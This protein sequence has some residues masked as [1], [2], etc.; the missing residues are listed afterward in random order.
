MVSTR[1]QASKR[2][3]EVASS[4][5]SSSEAA[6]DDDSIVEEEAEEPPKPVCSDEEDIHDD[7]D[8]DKD[9]KDPIQRQGSS[10]LFAPYRSVGIVNSGGGFHLVPNQNSAQA[11]AACPIGDRFQLLQCDRLHPVLVSQAVATAA[12]TTSPAHK[13]NKEAAERCIQQV[14][15]DASL[16]IAVA[17]HGPTGTSSVDTVTLFQRTQPIASRMLCNRTK[18]NVMEVLSLGRIHS[19]VT[20]D[21]EKQGKKEN[22]A[23]IAVILAKI[24]QDSDDSSVPVVGDDDDNSSSSSDDESISSEDDDQHQETCLGRIVIL[25]ASRTGLV[26]H[27]RIALADAPTFVPRTGVHPATFLNKI[28]LG[29]C[30]IKN[31]KK[32]AACI[33]VNVRTGKIVHN[34]RCVA[35]SS[36]AVVTAL[37]QAPA[38]DTVAI[39]TDRG[40]VHLVNLKYDKVLFTLKHKAKRG[41]PVTVTSMSFRTDGSAMQ[42][43]IAPMAVGRSDGNVTVWDLTKPEDEQVGRTILCEMDNVHPG[44]VA[45]LEYFPQEPLLLSTGTTSNSIRMHIFD[46]PDHSSRLLRQRNGHTAPPTRIRYLHPGAGAGNGLMVNASDGTDASSCQILSSGGRDR[47]LRIFSTA[48]SV[49]DKEFSQGQGLEKKA[50]KLGLEDRSELLL[51]SLTALATSEVRSRDWGDL[52]TI[53]QDHSLAYVWNTQRGAQSGPVLRQKSWNVSNMQ[54][55]PPSET[56]ATAV[57]IS[58][59][60]NFALIGTKGGTIYRYNV[61]SGLARGSFPRDA[62]ILNEG[63]NKLGAIG[64]VNRTKKALEKKLKTASRSANL[65]KKWL[66]AQETAKKQQELDAKLKSACHDGHAVVGLAVDILNKTLLS[67]GSDAKLILWNFHTQAPHKKS[68]Y[69]L[70]CPAIKMCHVRDSDLAAIA[71]KDHSVVLFDCTALSVVRRFGKGAVRHKQAISDLCFSPDGRS[72]YT[73]SLDS[74]IRVWDV[75]TNNCIDWLGFKSPP[76]SI[77]ISP[78][79]EYLATTHAGKL[80]IC[81]WS[82]KSFY[83]TVHVDGSELVQ[84]AKMGE[85]MPIGDTMTK[86]RKTDQMSHSSSQPPV[87][88][89]DDEEVEKKCPAVAKEAGLI[90]LSGLPVAHWKNLFHLELVKERNKPK[91]APKKPPSAPFFL[92]WRSGEPISEVPRLESA[93]D[94]GA[95]D[96]D[97]WEAAWSDDGNDDALITDEPGSV[98]VGTKRAKNMTNSNSESKRRK[99]KHHRSH[100]ASLLIECGDNPEGRFRFQLV[101]DYISTQGP[102]AIDIALSSLCNG[103]HDLDNGLPLL[104][105]AS[106]WLSEACE[107]RERF[108]AINAYL[109]RF[110]HVHAFVIA[111]IRESFYETKINDVDVGSIEAIA[112]DKVERENRLQLLKSLSALKKAQADATDNLRKKMEHTICLLRHF[113]RMI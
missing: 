107:S 16:S 19:A 10:R 110:L 36:G 52:V 40:Q 37:E 105:L 95:D 84:P 113:S 94:E 106:Q 23:V 58:A 22:A 45:K 91:E 7:D 88:D 38:V 87:K 83:S 46:S 47:T 4:T 29:G 9:N 55:R 109:H 32:T 44:G 73:A 20:D 65:D 71:L 59:C 93:K 11:F 15:V 5:S 63:G 108:E 97:E 27:R 54:R 53:H 69:I 43:G 112:A 103:M 104:L 102:S 35:Q 50:K 26:V 77:T 18:W 86:G 17:S 39:G 60:G 51:P 111:G 101:T 13:K 89:G 96:D 64:N 78:T 8:D 57:A 67:V 41:G 42:Y 66:D 12:G 85:P 56:H 80:G 48:R 61:Q 100:L 28:L 98:E 34:F 2:E 49:L 14:V 62:T 6:S 74:T 79:G 3:E 30:S 24:Q 33:L 90:T 72:L 75:P 70:P 1:N 25:I 82:D 31:D 68:P 81:V 99:I 92:Q 76:T 21:I